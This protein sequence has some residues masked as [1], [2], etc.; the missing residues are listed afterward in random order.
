MRVVL[1]TKRESRYIKAE[2]R[3]KPHDGQTC[4]RM[5]KKHYSYKVTDAELAKIKAGSGRTKGVLVK[6]KGFPARYAFPEGR[7][8][9]TRSNQYIE[10]PASFGRPN[11]RLTLSTA[12]IPGNL[13]PTPPQA[14]TRPPPQ[15]LP[16][17]E[18][19]P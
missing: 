1:L 11:R 8:P 19:E 12:P 10:P 2:K 13:R 9:T 14:P 15:D 18:P 16:Q 7:R 5:G 6:M 3:R 4:V 17:P